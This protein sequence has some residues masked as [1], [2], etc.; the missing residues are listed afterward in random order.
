MGKLSLDRWIPPL[1][2][3]AVFVFIAVA[4][5]RDGVPLV[6]GGLLILLT[7]AA[8]AVPFGVGFGLQLAIRR[9]VPLWALASIAVLLSVPSWLWHTGLT[10]NLLESRV[11]SGA[12]LV[13]FQFV[14]LR[15]GADLACKRKARRNRHSDVSVEA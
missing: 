11:L 10:I 2:L 1:I 14:F 13:L 15:I 8:G 5:V 9:E 7:V 6:F 3:A 12:I 4:L